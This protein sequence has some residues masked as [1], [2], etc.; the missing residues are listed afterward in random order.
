MHLAAQKLGLESD[1]RLKSSLQKMTS[2]V[3][4]LSLATKAVQITK[5]L[6][7][8]AAKTSQVLLKE[9]ILSL[10]KRLLVVRKGSAESWK[11]LTPFTVVHTKTEG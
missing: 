2:T 11:I 6:A 9:W 10:L 1:L 8:L 4:S 5:N 7:S 3:I